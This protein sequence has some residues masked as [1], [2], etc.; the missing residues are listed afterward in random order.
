MPSLSAWGAVPTTASV[1]TGSDVAILTASTISADQIDSFDLSPNGQAIVFEGKISGDTESQIYYKPFALTSSPKQ[2]NDGTMAC[3]QPQ[4]SPQST[5]DQYKVSA[6]CCASSD[7]DHCSAYLFD[8]S[9]L[10]KEIDLDG[11]DDVYGAVY[12]SSSGADDKGTMA[13]SPDGSQLAFVVSGDEGGYYIYIK[14]IGTFRSG[15]LLT[16]LDNG[17]ASPWLAESLPYNLKWSDAGDFLYFSAADRDS[18]IALYRLGSGY[19]MVRYGIEGDVFYSYALSG[20]TA[21]GVVTGSGMKVAGS[22]C[23]QSIGKMDLYSGEYTELIPSQKEWGARSSIAC[24]WAAAPTKDADKLV[25]GRYT[26]VKDRFSATMVRDADIQ[27]L[28][29]Y[30]VGDGSLENLTSLVSGDA[31]VSQ[32][33][34]QGSSLAYLQKNISG[35]TDRIKKVI[36]T[37]L[38]NSQV[39]NGR[40]S[41]SDDA[42]LSL[43]LDGATEGVLLEDSVSVSAY[44]IDSYDLLQDGKGVVWAGIKDSGG[45]HVVYIKTFD[46]AVG[47]NINETGF[48]CNDP[49]FSPVSSK[50]DYQLIMACCDVDDSDECHLSLVDSDTGS[51]VIAEDLDYE[52][53][54][55]SFAWSPDGA[56]VAYFSN[57]KLKTVKISDASVETITNYL[58]QDSFSQVKWSEEGDVIY[59]ATR[60]GT[61]QKSSLYRKVINGPLYQYPLNSD[62]LVL[63]YD[64]FDGGIYFVQRTKY[65]RTYPYSIPCDRPAYVMGV[66]KGT[67]S[68]LLQS[69]LTLNARCYDSIINT[70]QSDYLLLQ[71]SIE[72]K[73]IRTFETQW[74][75]SM[76]S[77]IYALN[78]QSNEYQNLTGFGA[79]D[80]GISSFQYKNKNLIYQRTNVDGSN[81]D[82]LVVKAVS[83]P[84]S[85]TTGSSSDSG[86]SSTSGSGS[87]SGSS[88]S[89][90]GSSA[91]SG[92]SSSGSSGSGSSG[93]ASSESSGGYPKSFEPDTTLP[94]YPTGGGDD[95]DSDANGDE[96]GG[97]LTENAFQGGGCSLVRY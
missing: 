4:F 76:P 89:E 78:K 63:N 12:E 66:N 1:P 23:D 59:F 13:W 90:S 19:N 83:Y 37:G 87:S 36:L 60:V 21:V 88:S 94:A 31:E 92:S 93:S 11:V 26:Q 5:S 8:E 22:P 42:I 35:T 57:H 97:S 80:I 27:N 51:A 69:E 39:K 46:R 48:N 56:K 70:D 28:Y 2:L 75:A 16:G 47:I 29:L 3:H 71:F 34:V 25:V 54:D 15:T 67:K 74:E 6:V 85:A 79:D 45:D 73:S 96:S 49:R 84:T 72:K 86:S 7:R 20:S 9:G 24:Y 43:A 18:S 64:A 10:A 55:T 14:N 81:N 40:L 33:Q 30:N 58:A 32:F 68:M 50:S 61:D 91:S 38:N 62:Y 52:E 65:Y 95:A 44:Q 82:E 53:G 41:L 77:N 17:I